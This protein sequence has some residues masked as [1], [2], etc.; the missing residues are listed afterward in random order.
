MSGLSIGQG[1]GGLAVEGQRRQLSQKNW[2]K[3]IGSKE[4]A[5]WK[6][7]SFHPIEAARLAGWNL[8]LLLSIKHRSDSS[9][10]IQRT[11]QSK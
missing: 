2:L 4:L 8:S 6:D 3:R 9:A 5:Q 10:L 7:S 11:V 1:A